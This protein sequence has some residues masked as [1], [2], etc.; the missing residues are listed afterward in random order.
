[1]ETGHFETTRLVCRC[2]QADD[3]LSIGA[4]IQASFPELRPWMNWA[5]NMPSVDNCRRMVKERRDKFRRGSRY[6]FLLFTVQGKTLV[7]ECGLFNIDAREARAEVG[8]WCSTRA[9]G[10]GYI[11][12]AVNGLL[13]WAQVTVG[14]HKFILRCDERN[15][16]SMAVAQRCGFLPMF[17]VVNDDFDHDGV[18]HNTVVFEKSLP[19]LATIPE[20]HV[21]VSK[22]L[23]RSC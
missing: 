14:I 4:A 18:M 1:M 11:S 19:A 8:Y 15:G 16:R 12:E 17:R 3:S 9:V 2:P 13:E 5:K 23:C 6:D 7:G 10:N 20:N 22:A 21:G